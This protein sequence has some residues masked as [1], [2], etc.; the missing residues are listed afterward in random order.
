ML[1]HVWISETKLDDFFSGFC[2]TRE[3]TR[4]FEPCP[5]KETIIWRLQ[6]H[7]WLQA[8]NNTG[9]LSTYIRLWLTE[10]EQ[11]TPMDQIKDV[12]QSSV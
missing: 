12:V 4:N 9:I 5:S 3:P 8:S 11:A 2:R 6:V 10:S 7:S 1:L